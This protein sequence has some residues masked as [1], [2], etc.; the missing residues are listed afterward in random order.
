M[1][2]IK[3]S[4]WFVL[5]ISASL[6]IGCGQQASEQPTTPIANAGEDQVVFLNLQCQLDGS[7][8]AGNLAVYSWKPVSYPSSTPPALVSS[9]AKKAYFTPTALGTFEFELDLSNSLGAS[10]AEVM[11]QVIPFEVPSIEA[12]FYGVC[13]HL[14]DHDDVN[15]LLQ[16]MTEAGIQFVRYDFDWKD[17]EPL[18]DQ[19]VFSKYD[20]VVAQLKTKGLKTLGILDYGNKWSDPTTGKT[21]EINRF[22]DF[23][24]NTVKHFKNDIKLW[25]IWNEPNSELFW[26]SPE[27]A[28]Y[29]KLLK[30]AYAAVKQADPTAAVILGGLVGNGKDEIYISNIRFAK[31]NYLSDIYNNGGK[32]YFDVADIHPYTFSIDIT[33][34]ASLETAIAD[35]KAI[36]VNSGDGGKPLWITELGPLFFPPVPLPYLSERG[37]TDEEVAAWLNLIYTNLKGKCEKLFWYEMRD[38]PGATTI[39]N[40]NWEGLLKADYS[41]KAG[42]TV[43]KNLFK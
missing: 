14:Q 21:D 35:T 41:I 10:S 31:L 26:I 13:A 27:A 40:P 15:S 37:Y 19:F 36:M 3:R 29:T 33:S 22:A 43:Y 28:N 30:S 42:F 24:Y 20:Q 17:I 25:Q 18:D 11:I 9:N 23:A 32:D 39:Y 4:F 34:T 2:Q 16:P 6:L 12:G 5:V 7:R 1:V 8:S 38:Y